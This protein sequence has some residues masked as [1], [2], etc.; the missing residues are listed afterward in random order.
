[1]NTTWLKSPDEF[2]S[3]GDSERLALATT[4]NSR[5]GQYIRRQ[6]IQHI[7]Y[8]LTG[9]YS[10]NVTH[11]FCE[12][13]VKLTKI[14]A[15]HNINNLIFHNYRHIFDLRLTQFVNKISICSLIIFV[16]QLLSAV[17]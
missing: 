16:M 5:S 11:H 7:G 3:S 13:I 4:V 1:V 12:F 6:Y 8:C 10:L 17:C 14:R 2:I 9:V 15:M